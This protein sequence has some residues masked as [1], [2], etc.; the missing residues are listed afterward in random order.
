[1]N[2]ILANGVFDVF[3]IGHLRYLEAARAL[4]SGP[5]IVSVTRDSHV[6]KGPDRPMF[7]QFVRC[8][9]LRAL[10]IVDEVILCD[11]LRD[12]MVRTKPTIVVKGSEYKG[13]MLRTDL[14]YMRSHGIR[15]EFTDTMF[16]SSTKIIA[17]GLVQR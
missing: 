5:L 15:L 17:D 8:A 11:D 6:N 4:D 7:D 2:V 14:A 16:A 10:A 1:M 9:I 13:K 3:H 12:A